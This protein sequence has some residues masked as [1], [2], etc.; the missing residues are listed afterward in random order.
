M[1]C[2]GAYHINYLTRVLTSLYLVCYSSA[3]TNDTCHFDIGLAIWLFIEGIFNP[4]PF[5]WSFEDQKQVTDWLSHSLTCPRSSNYH[6][7]WSQVEYYYPNLSFFWWSCPN[8]LKKQVAKKVP[9]VNVSS[10]LNALLLLC[11]NVGDIL[12]L[13]L[14]CWAKI[15]KSPCY[16]SL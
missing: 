8:V 13:R 15:T 12:V 1:S 6:N 9:S 16:L 2:Q 5:L 3:W 4:L 11:H 14:T 7:M 10:I